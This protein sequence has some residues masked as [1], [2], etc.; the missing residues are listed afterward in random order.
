MSW[1]D[2]EK[3]E[4]WMFKNEESICKLFGWLIIVTAF[5]LLG[6]VVYNGGQTQ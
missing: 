6:L 1:F 3:F 4:T 2:K 5:V